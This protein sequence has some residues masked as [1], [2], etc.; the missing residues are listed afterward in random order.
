MEVEVEENARTNPDVP[1]GMEEGQLLN[2]RMK[3]DKVTIQEMTCASP[4]KQ[5][6]L[7]ADCEQAGI[8]GG[9]HGVVSTA[10][11]AFPFPTFHV[12]RV[13]H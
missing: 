11:R 13:T 12:L 9:Q 1:F 5:F 2:K 6:T 4:P 3:D 10:L 7:F 8:G